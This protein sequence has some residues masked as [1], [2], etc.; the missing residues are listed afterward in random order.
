LLSQA[1]ASQQAKENAQQDRAR[2]SES[3]RMKRVLDAADKEANE[4]MRKQALGTSFA[5]ALGI[6]SSYAYL[7]YSSELPAEE[8][9]SAFTTH[10]KRAWAE[11]KNSFNSWVDPPSKKLLPDPLPAGYQRPY[12]LLIELTDT[13][14][15]M[16]WEVCCLT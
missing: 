9:D 15:H 6:I 14:C 4:K 2:T 13:L 5:V 10:N 3:E 11:V 12:T 1:R 16:V 8:G 7:G